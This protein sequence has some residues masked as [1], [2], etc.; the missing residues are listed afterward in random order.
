[1]SNEGLYWDSTPFIPMGGVTTATTGQT[2]D[3]SIRADLYNTGTAATPEAL[4]KFR[5][6]RHL[7]PGIKQLHYGVYND[8]KDYEDLVHGV[9]T[10][11]SDHVPDCIKGS[12]LNGNKYF[13]NQIAESQYPSNKREPLGKSIMRNYNFPEEVKSDGFRFGIPTKGIMN[14]K[15]VIYNGALLDEPPD[16]KKLYNKTHGFTDPGEQQKR[17]YKW[18]FDPE[19]H[20]FGYYIDKELDGAKKS[21]MTDNLYSPYP[22]TKIVDKRLED[23]RSASTDMLGKSKYFG[24]LNPKYGDDFAY[25]KR[26]NFGDQWN[27]GRCIH[28]DAS[29]VS[30]KSV[31]PDIDLGRDYHYAC[32]LKNLQPIQRDPNKV[33]GVPSIRSDLPKREYK[34]VTDPK[35]YGDEP[36]VYELLYPHPCAIRNVHDEDFDVL[37]T[38]DEIYALMKKYDFE[39]PEEEY[40]LIYQVGLKNYPNEEGKMSPKS[41]ISTMRNLKREYQKYRT[42]VNAAC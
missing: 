15:D 11:S 21:L 5:N 29:T 34:K 37:Y 22:E 40:N 32:K 38:K 19:N 14:A 10:K 2:A 13:M 25:G 7:I 1:M 27:A 33:Y 36:D 35:N 9:P 20:I 42:L 18:M 12:N 6:T 24:T 3:L 4:A 16:V 28:G 39:I 26:S 23:F 17:D 31:A 30:E 41:F 8:P